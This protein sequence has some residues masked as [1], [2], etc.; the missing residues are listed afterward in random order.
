MINSRNESGAIC[1]MHGGEDEMLRPF[2][3]DTGRSLLGILDIDGI[4]II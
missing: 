1:S 3:G 2:G 4:I